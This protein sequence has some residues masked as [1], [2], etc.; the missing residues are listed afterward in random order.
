MNHASV[1]NTAAIL[2]VVAFCT[3]LAT[4]NE[5]FLNVAL[6]PIMADLVVDTATVQWV[7]TAY[8]LAAAIMVPVTG[9]LYRSMLTNRLLLI[10]LA[11]LLL[12]TVLGFLATSFP[13]LLTGRIV[14]ALGTGMVV[15]I[16]MNLTLAVAPKGKLGTY[17]GVV[18][19]MTTLGP[20]FGPIIA[21][22]LL[23]VG[24]WHMLFAAFAVLV[25]IAIVSAAVFV[26]NA[27]ELT[28]PK[29]DVVSTCLISFALMGILYG[30]S[31]VF[32]G[33]LPVAIA[34]LV[35][36]AGCLC[37]FVVRQR[38]MAEP[39]VDLRP[40][41]SRSF[42]MGLVV[43]VIALMTVFSMNMILPLFMQGSLGFSAFD[44]A[45]TLLP[46]CILSCVLA[47]LAGRV[48]DRFGLRV[49]LPVGLALMG[50]FA[51]AL[52]RCTQEVTSMTI[53]L[54]YAPVIIGCALT[55]GPAQSFALSSL[56]PQLY[57]HGVTIVSTSFQIA[58]CVGSSLFVGV[59]SGVQTSQMAAGFAQ[60][61]ATV[62]GFQTSCLVAV[63]IAVVGFVLS[64]AM[65]RIERKG[66]RAVEPQQVAEKHVVASAAVPSEA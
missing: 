50:V 47:P 5:T 4:F 28:K 13:L 11:L 10:A 26:P 12:G 61:A 27:A 21:G 7:T 32:S 45:L 31:T 2:F 34:T 1:K 64:L 22:A 29:L 55:M 65:G 49:M 15:P 17:M 25:L 9:F 37:G 6:T 19:A 56:K 33:A 57:P 43:I 66:K 59:L 42:T 35:V 18:G 30:I 24:D 52:S 20:A 14:Q 36:G 62:A 39:L 60:T 63:A 44:A 48:Y 41:A 58:G 40:F 23:A 3:L 54:C 38:K 8:M 51:F 46:A 16:G 53:V